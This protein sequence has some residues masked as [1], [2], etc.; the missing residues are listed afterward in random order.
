[1]E[2]DSNREMWGPQPSDLLVLRLQHHQLRLEE[3]AQ[4][5][6]LPNATVANLP[7]LGQLGLSRSSDF[8][9]LDHILICTLETLL[10]TLDELQACIQSFSDWGNL[11]SNWP[12]RGCPRPANPR[13][14][15]DE[16]LV[17]VPSATRSSRTASRLT[18]PIALEGRWVDREMTDGSSVLTAADVSWNVIGR[19]TNCVHAAPVNVA[20]ERMVDAV[21]SKHVRDRSP[22]SPCGDPS[23]IVTPT[24]KLSDTASSAEATRG[25]SKEMA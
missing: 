12:H 14:P 11:G 24:Q 15:A 5:T 2:P 3:L 8:L 21:P 23:E 4:Q 9:C 17:L 25:L 10:R 13:Q 22:A 18:A 19:L 6:W 1:M 20:N 7:A 16:S